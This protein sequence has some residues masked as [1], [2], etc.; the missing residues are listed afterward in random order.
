MQLYGSRL[1]LFA[2]VSQGLIEHFLYAAVK[3]LGMDVW[4]PNLV[5][6]PTFKEK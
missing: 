1:L 2:Q 5:L 4:E 3:A 6:N